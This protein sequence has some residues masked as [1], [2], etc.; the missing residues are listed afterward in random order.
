MASED[1]SIRCIYRHA[2]KMSGNMKTSL[3]MSED[4]LEMSQSY[5]VLRCHDLLFLFYM[6]QLIFYHFPVNLSLLTSKMN[7]KLC[8]ILSI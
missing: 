7:D 6:F 1:M 3:K 4:V 8:D 2:L 5:D